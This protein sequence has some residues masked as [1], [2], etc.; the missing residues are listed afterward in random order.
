MGWMTLVAIGALEF[1]RQLVRSLKTVRMTIAQFAQFK[2]LQKVGTFVHLTTKVS[3]FQIEHKDF[4]L[5]HRTR[6]SWFVL[7]IRPTDRQTQQK[8]ADRPEGAKERAIRR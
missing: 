3:V 4:S 1:D 2:Q 7:C 6:P 8:S 5:N